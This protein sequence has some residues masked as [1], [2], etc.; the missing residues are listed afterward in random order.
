MT[1][2]IIEL[3]DNA[4]KAL[5]EIAIAYGLPF[6]KLITQ[7]IYHVLDSEL[8]NGSDMTKYEAEGVLRRTGY[9]VGEWVKEF[10]EGGWMKG[11]A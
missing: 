11:V 10:Q 5:H 2:L 6:D 1:K 8:D 7:E 4:V 9:K 3:P